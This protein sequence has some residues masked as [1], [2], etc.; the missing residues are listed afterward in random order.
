MGKTKPNEPT[1]DNTSKLEHYSNIRRDEKVWTD[2]EKKKGKKKT[3]LF[4]I[5]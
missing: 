3:I 4:Y 1:W 5:P 2:S